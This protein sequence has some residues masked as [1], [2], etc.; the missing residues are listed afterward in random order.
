[1]RHHT[2]FGSPLPRI[3]HREHTTATRAREPG[4]L[5]GVDS[6]ERAIR[7]FGRCRFF[8]PNAL[9]YQ[10]A[11][12]PSALPLHRTEKRKIR[13]DAALGTLSHDYGENHGR[14]MSRIISRHR[15]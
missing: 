5:V 10:Q 1:M 3:P 7:L 6:D 15:A 4:K 11:A 8:R 14:D 12:K 2:V 13:I 9:S